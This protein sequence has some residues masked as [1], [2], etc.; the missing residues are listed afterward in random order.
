[1]EDIGVSAK[2]RRLVAAIYSKLQA[3]VRGWNGL[4]SE[5][6]FIRRGVPE[7]DTMSPF[8]F[9]VSLAKILKDVPSEPVLL[10][11]GEMIGSLEYADDVARPKA[12]LEKAQAD[13]DTLVE[14]RSLLVFI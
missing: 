6:F 5:S 2:L 14:N 9:I 10:S 1:L 13:I 7:G 12:D 11:T 4:V 8:L 3:R